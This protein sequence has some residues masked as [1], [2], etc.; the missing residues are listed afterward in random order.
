VG[1][2]RRPSKPPRVYYFASQDDVSTAGH[3]AGA[4]LNVALR[5]LEVRF[6]RLGW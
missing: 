5:L 2:V 6:L 4:D 3:E 1:G